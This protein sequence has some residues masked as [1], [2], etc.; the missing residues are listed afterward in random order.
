MEWNEPE[1]ICKVKDYVLSVTLI[2]YD[3]CETKTTS[4]TDDTTTFSQVTLPPLN[5]FST[6]LVTVQARSGDTTR[7]TGNPIEKEFT[8]AESGAS[9]F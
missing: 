4:I 9:L 7:G 1:S 5:Y 8:T 2:N 3:Q 6:Y